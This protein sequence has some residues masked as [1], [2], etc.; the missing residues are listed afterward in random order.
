M[1]SA[2]TCLRFEIT[3]KVG[4]GCIW[5][6]IPWMTWGH[7]CADFIA[8]LT[9]GKN[10]LALFVFSLDQATFKISQLFCFAHKQLE[11]SWDDVSTVLFSMSVIS[12]SGYKLI[13]CQL[14]IFCT[15]CVCHIFCTAFCLYLWILPY[16]KKKYIWTDMHRSGGHLKECL[17]TSRM[18]KFAKLK[19]QPAKKCLFFFLFTYCCRNKK[20]QTPFH[21]CA[22][23]SRLTSRF[24]CWK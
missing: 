3:E 6:K 16:F 1:W 2:I 17:G 14:F 12:G 15:F 7:C 24:G 4:I 9:R 22:L 19:A 23:V 21:C 18:D 20:Q 5:W 10:D 13:L 8:I 11:T